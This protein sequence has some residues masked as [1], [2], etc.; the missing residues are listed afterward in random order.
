MVASFTA[1]QLFIVYILNQLINSHFIVSYNI[2]LHCDTKA[3]IYRY[4][5]IVYRIVRYITNPDTQ[6]GFSM[7]HILMIMMMMIW[8]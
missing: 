5:Q 2:L 4:I 8:R 1:L 7:Q 3:A 6:V